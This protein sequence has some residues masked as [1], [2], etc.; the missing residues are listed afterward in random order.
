MVRRPAQSPFLTSSK[1]IVRIASDLE[2]EVD[3]GA[4]DVGDDVPWVE[5]VPFITEEEDVAP[6][7]AASVLSDAN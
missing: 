2:E 3:A 1:L 6:S 4:E 7:A 5:D